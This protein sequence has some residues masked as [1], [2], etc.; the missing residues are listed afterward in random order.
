VNQEA[1]IAELR[2]RGVDCTFEYPGYIA[3]HP[4]EG[5]AMNVSEMNGETIEIQ[6]ADPDGALLEVIESGIPCDCD[7]V[8]RVADFLVCAYTQALNLA[9]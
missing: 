3:M 7:D 1:I 4:R 5:V 6:V 2:G 9:R 8:M